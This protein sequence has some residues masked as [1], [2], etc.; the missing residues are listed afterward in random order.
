MH[1]Y[2]GNAWSLCVFL[3]SF[4]TAHWIFA[5]QYWSLAI[6][7]QLVVQQ[8][9]VKHLGLLLK[10]M[11]YVGEV[12][13]CLTGYLSLFA[14]NHEGAQ[15]NTKAIEN[16]T[17]FM[18]IFPELVS[19]CVLVDALR[20]LRNITAG[21]FAIDTAQMI[22][23]IAGFTLVVGTGIWLTYTTRHPFVTEDGSDKNAWLF[24]LNLYCVVVMV[25]LAE[26]PFLYIINRLITQSLRAE[27]ISSEL[28][29]KQVEVHPSEED[30]V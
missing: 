14:F 9:Q 12:L 5:M 29:V 3:A 15:Y 22:L 21:Q 10:L 25:F 23:H 26:L 13:Q 11:F 18:N 16:W 17:D 6:K 19:L 27:K 24:Y 4:N 2:K 20:R 8:K 7:L 28:N 1:I 30:L